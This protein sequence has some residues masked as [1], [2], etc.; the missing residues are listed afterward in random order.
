ML[1]L[2]YFIASYYFFFLLLCQ[3]C[4]YNLFIVYLGKKIAYVV[5]GTVSGFTLPLETLE[6]VSCGDRSTVISCKLRNVFIQCTYK[7]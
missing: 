4:K 6:H 3:I 7:R 5:F 2:F 1:E